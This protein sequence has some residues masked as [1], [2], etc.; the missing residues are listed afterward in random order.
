M[1]NDFILSANIERYSGSDSD[2]HGD[3]YHVSASALKRLKKSPAHFKEEELEKETEALLFGSAYHCFVLEPERFKSDY[4]IFD[5][6]IQCEAIIA[7]GYAEG[8]EV[9]NVRATKEYKT[10]KDQEMSFNDG[11]ILLDKYDYERLVAMKERLFKHPYVKMLLSGGINEQSYM[12]TIETQSG[13]IPVKIKPDHINEH[14]KFIVDLKTCFDASLDG[15][16]RAAADMD[17]QIQAAFYSDIMEL[18]SGDQRRYDFYF[19]AQEKKPPYAFNLFEC[20]PQFISQGRFE[21]ELLL[22]LYKHCTDNNYWPG[23]QVWCQNK[24]GIL[25]LKLPPWA[26]KDVNWYDHITK[27]S[28]INPN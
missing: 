22:G 3:K 8:K 21:Y 23:Y 25:E 11:K 2:Y 20:G 5:D 24:Y 14:K 7:K 15:F 28:I 1:E 13:S 18:V 26:I 4:Y 9:K 10:W 16:T 6:S 19:I 17:Y 12:G 27:T